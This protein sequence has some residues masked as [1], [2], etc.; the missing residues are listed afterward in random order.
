MSPRILFIADAG[1]AIGGGHVMRSLT[2]ARALQARGATC[3]F[4]ASAEV[5]AVL[6]V[7]GPDLAHAPANA[8]GEDFDAVV[9][10]HYGLGA[11]DHR[12]LAAGRPALVIDDLADR[13]LAA[14]ILLDAEPVRTATHYENLVAPT[15]ELLL[16]PAFAPVRAAFDHRRDQALAARAGRAPRRVLISLG[17]TDVGGITGR[18][19]DLLRPR[20]GDLALDVVVG[21]V[22]PSLPRLRRLKDPNLTLHV[23]AQDMPALLAQADLAIGAGGGSAWERCVLGLPSL[24]LVLADNQIDTAQ[25]L[26]DAGAAVALDVRA[27]SFDSALV[28][29]F[30]R[31]IAAPDTLARMSAAAAALCDGRGAER[32]ADRLLTRLAP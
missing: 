22:A 26:E 18:I 32:V 31:L 8:T 21:G 28:Q 30:D 9:L 25:A 17:L 1:P 12:R 15:T 24:C 13:P 11:D 5:A 20:L 6:D 2:L 16:G 29:A 10:D 3:A 14:D 23:D 19:V 4:A 27:P 7:F